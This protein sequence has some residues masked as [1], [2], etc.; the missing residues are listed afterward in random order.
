MGL[1]EKIQSK[2]QQEIERILSRAHRIKERELKIANQKKQQELKYLKE[3][4]DKELSII[5]TSKTSE[6]TL[7]YHIQQLNA[8]DNLVEDIITQAFDN[9]KRIPRDSRY[10]KILKNFIIEALKSLEIESCILHLNSQ[11]TDWIKPYITDLKQEI[12]TI[13][14][15]KKISLGNPIETTGGVIVSSED[16]K[17]FFD[18]TFEERLKKFKE[19]IKHQILKQM[20]NV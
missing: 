19:E 9:L 2:T 8:L 6:I 4:I 18:N 11:D 5:K 7:K 10:L 20:G 16:K 3:Q 12:N 14:P 17:L 15:L 1:K 13:I